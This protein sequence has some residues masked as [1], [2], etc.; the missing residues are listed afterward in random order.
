MNAKILWRQALSLC[1]W[2]AATNSF[3][4][5]VPETYTFTQFGSLDSLSIP[6]GD[7]S[8]VVDQRTISSPI[9][10]IRAVTISLDISSQYNGDIY[11]YVIHGDKF[12]VLLNRVGKTA[13]NEYGYGDSGFNVTLTSNPTDSDVHEYQ[14]SLQLPVGTPLTGN[15]LADGRNVDPSVSL[16]TTERTAGLEVFAGDL[17]DGD[18]TVF[19]SDSNNGGTATLNSWSITITPVPE[20]ATWTLLVGGLAFLGARRY[21][22]S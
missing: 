10:D 19:L 2:L 13:D 16:D 20:P 8:G 21:R 9:T 3:A 15:W 14:L 1:V 11:A 12:A 5:D 22:K 4:Q 18:W 17:A 7:A 6:D